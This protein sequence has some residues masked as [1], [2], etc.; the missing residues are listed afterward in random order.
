MKDP[1]STE[2]VSRFGEEASS[3]V[4]INHSGEDIFESSVTDKRSSSA[5]NI[6][7]RESRRR[8]KKLVKRTP[9]LASMH[10]LCCG[11]KKHRALALRNR[12]AVTSLHV[13]PLS[14]DRGALLT[15]IVL[16]FPSPCCFI[17]CLGKNEKKRCHPCDNIKQPSHVILIVLPV[18]V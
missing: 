1:I 3:S 8:R 18:S 7:K 6:H 4:I 2:V 13:V 17:R 14:N 5:Q 10:L 16:T 12:L 11:R 15:R 9:R